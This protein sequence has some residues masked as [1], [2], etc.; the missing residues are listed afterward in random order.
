[1][2][3]RKTIGAGRADD[4]ADYR[5]AVKVCA[6][7]DHRSTAFENCARVRCNRADTAVFNAYLDY[8]RLLC[9]QVFLPFKRLLH[10]LLIASAV[11][12]RPQRMHSGAFAT[13]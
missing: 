4:L 7:C 12:L 5:S 8:L 10:D 3:G 9:A 1:M 13:V 11:G 2:F 6:A